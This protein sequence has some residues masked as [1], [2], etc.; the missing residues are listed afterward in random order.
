MSA[1]NYYRVHEKLLQEFS[2]NICVDKKFLQKK[3]FCSYVR[4][5]LQKKIFKIFS[6]EFFIVYVC[7]NFFTTRLR[8]RDLQPTHFPLD[9]NTGSSFYLCCNFVCKRHDVST[10]CATFI[11][12]HKRLLCI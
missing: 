3:F 5:V 1:Y 9:R 2:C 8:V 6:Y 11:N 7:A 12:E 4:K 10:R